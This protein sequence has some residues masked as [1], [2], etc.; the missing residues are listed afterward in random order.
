MQKQWKIRVWEYS[1]Q[2]W[3]AVSL[4]YMVTMVIPLI[5]I[6]CVYDPS[7]RLLVYSALP[8]CLQHWTTFGLF[9][10]EEARLM[11]TIITIGIPI[12]QLW[13]ISFDLVSHKLRL[14]V[15]RI[16]K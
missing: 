16:Q 2:D 4:P 14:I 11:L 7:M 9:I 3:I 5:V 1:M 15:R 13:V 12:F 8:N 10:I 6:A